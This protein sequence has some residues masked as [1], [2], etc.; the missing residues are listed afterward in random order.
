MLVQINSNLTQ[1]DISN[2]NSSKF[3][4]SKILNFKE[5]QAVIS[6]RSKAPKIL[7]FH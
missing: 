6:Q 5:K 7:A 2:S 3:S 4:Y 1:L